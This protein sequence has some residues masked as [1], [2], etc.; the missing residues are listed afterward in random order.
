MVTGG[1][2]P[3]PPDG[4][5]PVAGPWGSGSAGAAAVRAAGPRT[6]RMA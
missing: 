5:P 2:G 1:A 3:G 4:V 6:G